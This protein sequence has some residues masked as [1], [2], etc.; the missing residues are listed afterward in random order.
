MVENAI[1]GGWQG[2]HPLIKNTKNEDNGMTN[3][4]QNLVN[5]KLG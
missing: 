2:V 3:Y 4:L 1:A 5:G